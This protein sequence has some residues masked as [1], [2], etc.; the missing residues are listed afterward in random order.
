MSTRDEILKFINKNHKSSGA[1][2]ARLMGKSRQAINKHLKVLVQEGKIEKIG[3]TKG[4]VYVPIKDGEKKNDIILNKAYSLSRL[5]EDIVFSEIVR[6]LNLKR[7][8]R[9]NVFEIIQY[10]FTE[11]LNNAIEHSNSERG[12]VFISLETYA[13]Q[14]KIRDFGIGIYNSIYTKFG[15]SDENAAV[16]ELLKG[17]T[18]TMRERHSGEGIFFTSKSVDYASFRSH[19]INIIFNNKLNDV[20]VEERKFIKGTEVILNLS[21]NSKKS[22]TKIFAEYAPEEYEYQFERTRVYVKLFQQEYVSRS[23][24]KRLLQGLNKFK[25]VILNF[26]GVKSL[27]QGFCDE[28]F[29]VFKK[30]FPDIVIKIENISPQL[31]PMIKHIVDNNIIK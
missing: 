14:I 16:G 27:G 21:R 31:Q 13:C 10:I 15:L 22:L 1:S 4:T 12:Q 8:I 18:T 24:A 3:T 11:I 9:K 7:K 5:E 29:R 30:R 26:K 25:E 6:R 28:V 2:L 19:K 20:Y 23:E 17:K